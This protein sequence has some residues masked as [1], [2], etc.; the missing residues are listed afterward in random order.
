MVAVAI[1]VEVGG[2]DGH[3]NLVVVEVVIVA[4]YTVV[5]FF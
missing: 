3:E 1:L 5:L 4:A 2:D